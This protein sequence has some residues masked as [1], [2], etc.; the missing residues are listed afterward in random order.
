MPESRIGTL[1]VIGMT[2]V[3]RRSVYDDMFDAG[4]AAGEPA[5]QK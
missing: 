1:V 3:L 5:A 2:D 4:V